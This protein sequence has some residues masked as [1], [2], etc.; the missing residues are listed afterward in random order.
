MPTF[1]LDEDPLHALPS[2]VYR[3][4]QRVG[5]RARLRP[6]AQEILTG[7]NADVPPEDLL[8]GEGDA[9]IMCTDK[10]G[11]CDDITFICGGSKETSFDCDDF[12]GTDE[13]CCN[14]AYCDCHDPFVCSYQYDCAD[15]D[16]F[17][18][19]RFEC[20][21]DDYRC[22]MTFDFICGAWTFQCASAFD[23]TGGHVFL[24]ADTFLC[25]SSEEFSCAATGD[26]ACDANNPYSNPGSPDPGDFLCGTTSPNLDSF[27][28]LT[29]FDC[30]AASDFLC[31]DTTGFGCMNEF[32]CMARI[33]NVRATGRDKVSPAPHGA[34]SLA[35]PFFL[36]SIV[37]TKAAGRA[38]V[39]ALSSVIR[40][41]LAKRISLAREALIAKCDMDRKSVGQLARETI[42]RARFPSLRRMELLL[43]E[44]CN[45]SCS[46]CYEKTGKQPA[47]MMPTVA[48]S[49]VDLLF[50]ESGEN[51]CCEIHFLGGEPLLEFELLREVTEY[52][53][54]RAG[55]A[56][57]EI[58]FGI[59][60]N[61]LL[62][63]EAHLEFFRKAGVTFCLSLDGAPYWHNRYRRTRDGKGS[64]ETVAR[65]MRLL[66]AYQPWQGARITVMPETAKH[67]RD[68]I[69]YLHEQQ[70][71]NQFIIGFAT[72]VQW[73]K[74]DLV[75]YCDGLRE[76]FDYYRQQLSGGSKNLKI[77][78]F[79]FANAS[80][81]GRGNGTVGWGCGAG[82]SRVAVNPQG[83]LHGCSK[84]AWMK[85]R[86]E[87]GFPLGTVD[88]GFTNLRNRKLLLDHTETPRRKCRHCQL[89]RFC[90]GGCY[91]ASFV[92]TGN[93]YEPSDTYC[94][95]M[96]AQCKALEYAD[97]RIQRE[98]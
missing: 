92:D 51:D 6:L 89:S 29:D 65:K 5:E 16:V 34:S 40:G 54:Q 47:S 59:Q 73:R 11:P 10:S 74:A 87:G 50:R 42:A 39:P 45:M 57:K 56:K 90:G 13:F 88:K 31:T 69:T 79:S 91:A 9:G 67:L 82:V 60:T 23:C 15:S 33:S 86:K 93:I 1:N 2:L 19:R 7:L 24:C 63:E 28:C 55:E 8:V 49:A 75:D 18:C 62:L 83:L 70:R 22:E 27:A 58:S 52:A 85:R 30:E 76:T 14:A 36:T 94:G 37:T 84:L 53:Q 97:E 77:P 66:K 80:T 26:E 32:D 61:G 25:T 95:L 81:G 43:T 38:P 78:F 41:S 35:G 72:N 21:T 96:F 71:I 68:N 46:Y 44:A 17:D 98:G 64:F 48:K 20:S 3:A 4:I 12:R